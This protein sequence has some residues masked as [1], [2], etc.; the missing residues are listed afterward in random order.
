VIGSAIGDIE[1]LGYWDIV[2]VYLNVSNIQ[3]PNI[4]YPSYRRHSLQAKVFF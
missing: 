1:I 2:I 3:Y 4:Q